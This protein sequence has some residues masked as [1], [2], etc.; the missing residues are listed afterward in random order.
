MT[1]DEALSA[2]ARLAALTVLISSLEYLANPR[3]L[4]DDGLMNWSV[5]RLR[6]M[7][8]SAGW[9]SSFFDALLRYPNVLVLLVLRVVLASVALIAPISWALAP[10]V[11]L[12]LFLSLFLSNA[13]SNYGHD[14][15]DQLAG[16]VILGI[17]LS[18]L[19]P[20]VLSRTACLLFF[21][22]QG[23]LAYATAGWCKFPVAGWRDGTYLAAV[24]TTEIYGKPPLGRYLSAHPTLAKLASRSVLTW[25]C[26]FPLVLVLPH[27]IAFGLL[28]L[29]VV[30]HVLNAFVMGLNCF[31]WSFLAVYPPLV[32][33]I[34]HRGW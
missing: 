29:G 24:L 11:L 30:F 2:A 23:C 17:G 15:A 21:A 3:V 34:Q 12:G 9:S 28:A 27:S 22:F 1:A 33:T 25:E 10:T 8:F 26:T 14:G 19:V 7:T 16:F 5:G 20:T 6:V 4:R 18:G 32:W 31:L 13:R